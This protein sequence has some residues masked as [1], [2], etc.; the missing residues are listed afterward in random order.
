M[1][2]GTRWGDAD[3][4]V[5]SGSLAGWLAGWPRPFHRIVSF[6]SLLLLA[7]S[8]LFQFYGGDSSCKIFFC[9]LLPL[10]FLLLLLLLLVSPLP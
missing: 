2:A 1:G 10:L 7:F 3:S 9:G 4:L 8:A 5:G 6:G